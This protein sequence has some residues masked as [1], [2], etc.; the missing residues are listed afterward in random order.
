MFEIKNISKKFGEEYALKSVT[1]NMGKGLSFI[2]GSSGSGKTTLLKIISGMEQDFE[3]EVH[4]CGQSI[5][6][7]S[8]KEK[9]YFYNNVFGFVWQDFNLLDDLTVLE[10][11]MLPQYLKQEKFAPDK[12]VAMKVLRALKIGELATQKAGK[13]SGG[14]KQ[15]VAIARE[16]VKNPQVIIA[17]EPT[18]AL[19]E[20][21]AKITMDILRDISKNRMVIVVT[22]DTTLID[23]KEKVY[24]L[25]KG[26]LI[27]A[28]DTV[29]KTS[30]KQGEKKQH[31]LTLSNA[32]K[33]AIQNIKSK[34]GR[35]AITVLSLLVATILLLVTVSG[36][37]TD[38]SQRA[39]DQLFETYGESIL[40]ISIVGSFT[41]AGGTDGSQKDEPSADV[42]QNIDGLYD[43]YKGDS[44]VQHI[45]FTQAFQDIKT[46][47][48]GKDY[49]VEGSNSVPTVNKL[50]AGV[51]P[52]GDG[53]EVVVPNSFVKAMGLTDEEAI[54]K[55]VN[56]DASVYN[57]DSGEPVSSKVKTTAEIVGV[58]DTTVRYDAGD[59]QIMDY[60]VDDAFFFSKSALDDMRAQ[61]KIEKSD[62]NFTIRTKTPADLIAMKDELNAE[63]I[64]PLGQF[65]LV[66]DM[67]RL[68]SQTMQQSSSAIVVIGILSVVVVLAVSMMTALTRKREYAI[69]KVSGY[70][71]GY[72]ARIIALE[73]AIAAIGGSIVFL[74]ASPLINMAT[75]AFWSVNILNGK[76]LFMGVLLLFA[77][78]ILSCTITASIGSGVK[79]STSL[80]TGDR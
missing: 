76:L 7:L 2:I 20:A 35:F 34:W 60:S 48:D 70:R 67:V 36:S 39:F 49:T 12:K 73:Y 27:A 1:M 52:M 58:V 56:F 14:Q 79:A 21:S 42:T 64:V 25:D 28:P 13:L 45:V 31:N 71:K 22:H 17:D 74:G 65:E 26:A 46:T 4:Y 16:L 59:G 40:D 57:W 38:S 32:G 29:L 50:T 51:M 75:T 62:I 63:G 78:G 47:V 8:E 41:S 33:I 24:A 18:S 19:D 69:Y 9:S 23:Q 5:K 77:M 66:E 6:A 11:I 44:R 55:E 10:N 61:A 3:G 68:N 37:I 80:K 72:I 15:R 30:N 54:G 53:A 43:R